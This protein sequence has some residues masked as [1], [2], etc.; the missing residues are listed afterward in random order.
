MIRLLFTIL[1]FATFCALGGAYYLITPPQG[2]PFNV[3]IAPEAS[4][5]EVAD[6]LQ[7]KGVIRS[8]TVFEWFKP[9]GI[10]PGFYV[11]NRGVYP[12]YAARVLEKGPPPPPDILVTIPEGK[13]L[14]EIAK[15]LQDSGI[16]E[17][18]E[19]LQ[20]ATSASFIHELVGQPAKTLEGYLFPDS[21]KFRPKT[22]ARKV[23]ERMYRR[24]D[25]QTKDISHIGMTRHEFLTL[26]SIVEK[27]AKKPEERPRIA[28]VFINR[29]TRG[30]RLESD[31]T[32]RY[33]INKW[34]TVPV[35]YADLESPSPYNTYRVSGLPPGPISSVGRASLEAVAKPLQ[36]NELFFVA[37]EDGSH[38]F[39]ENFSQ[40][41]ANIA[42]Y[43]K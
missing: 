17:G 8:A 40:H 37:R 26:A 9:Q 41:L 13:R 5:S 25:E 43:R 39:A 19:F 42:T 28:A 10:K 30:M 32:V 21:Y 34:D 33:A 35:L 27:E 24:L 11:F 15:I 22:D 16:I 20:L 12:W 1:I 6:L 36:T 18:D 4:L 2:G 38:V 14:V 29:I 3:T 31:P 23:I 7:E